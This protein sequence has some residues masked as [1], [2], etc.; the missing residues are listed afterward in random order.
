M[1]KILTIFVFILILQGCQVI[2]PTKVESLSLV[3]SPRI[4]E[5]TFLKYRN[6]FS[7]ALKT[8]LL[9]NGY[10]VNEVKLQ[11]ATSNNQATEMITTQL[12]DIGFLSKLS[13]FENREN[14]LEVL[15]SELEYSYNLSV[16][17]VNAWNNKDQL[18][19]NKVLLDHHF[20]GIYVG[21]SSKGQELYNK[22]K[23][24]VSL[25]WIDLN[26]SKWCHIV[27]TSQ[28]GYIYPSLWLIDN[29]SRRIAELFS[30]ELVV[31]GYPE[32]MSKLAS[33]ECD[34][35]VGPDMLREQFESAWTKPIDQDG[36][37]QSTSIYNDVKLIALS[38]P[39]LHDPVVYSNL[40]E[41]LDDSFV[42]AIKKSLM[43][44]ANAETKNPLLEAMDIKGFV[45]S[46][47]EAYDSFK[48][49]YDYLHSI[50]N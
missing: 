35:A 48:P 36:F 9:N 2:L 45:E 5:Q 15:L 34:I 13:Y 20:A 41:N 6:D 23:Q 29:F 30:H 33:Q 19:S 1:K 27:V 25:T 49:A 12:A 28:E 7:L 47:N 43:S 8:E 22:V 37:N 40:N 31:K 17:D 46:N 3:I 24:G 32:L 38:S 10:E 4:S 11:Y 50:F 42:S 16:D 26:S 44:L 14:N 18:N 21:S 39:I